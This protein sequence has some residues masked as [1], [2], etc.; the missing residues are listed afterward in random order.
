MPGSPWLTVKDIVAE[1]GSVLRMSP[2]TL[3]GTNTI[4]S[5]GTK[6]DFLSI[7]DE[8]SDTAM[9]APK[10]EFI[11]KVLTSG[12]NLEM[13]KIVTTIDALTGLVKSANDLGVDAMNVK[14]LASKTQL[15]ALIA[16]K[17]KP[18]AC[19]ISQG[20]DTQG[21][22]LGWKHMIGFLGNIV[23]NIKR[24]FLELSLQVKGGITYLPGA[25]AFA[26]YNTAMT[27]ATIEP[28]GKS[29]LTP[30]AFDAPDYASLLTGSIV[31]TDA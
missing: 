29:A 17:G 7:T 30:V 25:S 31:R 26:E 20:Y 24:D 11:K 21:V 8:S 18:F 27:T 28:V 2:I 14:V 19:M 15:E 6:I 12:V 5:F 9:Q 16:A 1:A 13:P 10:T 22:H 3:T 4:A 23:E